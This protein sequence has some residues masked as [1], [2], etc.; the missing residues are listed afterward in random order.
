MI[1]SLHKPAGLIFSLF[2]F[3]GLASTHAAPLVTPELIS[4]DNKSTASPSTTIPYQWKVVDGAAQY[5]FS[6]R[7]TKLK[8]DIH[9]IRLDADL[10]CGEALCEYLAPESV[11]MTPLG[12]YAWKVRAFN[13]PSRSKYA[14]SILFIGAEEPENPET[15]PEGTL[16]EGYDWQLPDYA[17]QNN[18]GGLLRD[19][20]AAKKDY[21]NTAFYSIRWY[22]VPLKADGSYNFADFDY[23]LNSGGGKDDNILVRLEVNSVCDTP[24]RFR[25]IFNYYAGGTIAFWQEEY[26]TELSAFVEAFAQTYANNPRIKGVHLGIADGEYSNITY[27][28]YAD[29]CRQDTGEKFDFFDGDD[30]WGEFWVN[31][32]ELEHAI[33]QGL[34]PDNF[35]PSVTQIIDAYTSAFG[36][37]TPKL[38]MTNLVNFVYNNPGTE[39]VSDEVIQT[40][41]AIKTTQITP[42]ASQKGVGNRDGLIEDWMAYNNPVYGTGFKPGPDK[43]CYMTMDENFAEMLDKRYWGTEN[44]EYGDEAWVTDRHGAFEEQPYRFMM[45]SLRALQM[46]RNHMQLNTTAMDTLPATDYKTPEFLSYLAST[47]GRDKTDTPDAF[48]VLGER[49]IRPEYMTGY[50]DDNFASPELETCLVPVV[51]GKA[52]YATVREYGRW[53]TEVSGQGIKSN[54][55]TLE[56]GKEPWS[57]PAY[58]PEVDGVTKYEYTAREMNELK[59]DI[60]DTVISNRCG[61]ESA[62]ELA[63]K[64]VFE[65]RIATTLSLVTESGVASTVETTGDGTTKTAT[66]EFNGT[67]ANAYDGA[68]FGVKTASES[69][70]L[71]VF[72]ARV[73]FMKQ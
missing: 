28:N 16:T 17:T 67:F 56:Q 19:T 70:R 36:D 57:V 35:L 62:C 59:F 55:M 6:I 7:D 23:W 1:L 37:H 27:G 21:T 60:N 54:L 18:R 50:T 5:D 22:E 44:E 71:P 15:Y 47:I 64:V 49:Y 68:D 69:E 11:E 66:F 9:T 26:I 31:E 4:P 25:D 45:S 46:R 42:Y 53:L 12:K 2:I 38:A 29:V 33:L 3:S 43:S 30:G 10:I 65:D 41:N 32:S 63:V 48:V 34:S 14:K 24:T 58:L 73:N 40:F 61:T 52:S 39:I 13:R 20:W 8:K 72:M 51:N